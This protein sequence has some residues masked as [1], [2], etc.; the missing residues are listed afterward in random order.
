[1]HANFIVNDGGSCADDVLALIQRA[2]DAVQ[3]AR[4]IVL[5]PEVRIVGRTR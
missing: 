2:Q 4:G 5:E 3:S 1:V